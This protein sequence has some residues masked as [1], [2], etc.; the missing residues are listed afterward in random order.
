MIRRTL[1]FERP[2]NLPP[3]Q[4][5]PLDEEILRHV[6]RHRFL[7]AD[8]VVGLVGEPKGSVIRRLV[9]LFEHGF[10]DRPRAQFR[11][12][13]SV[14]V[15]YRG[16]ELR[17]GIVPDRVFRLSTRDE[18]LLFCLEVDRGTMS[19]VRL[20]P[21][22]SSFYRK[23]LALPRDVAQRTARAG[24]GMAALPGAHAA[25]LDGAAR[26]LGRCAKGGGRGRRI[27]AVPLRGHGHLQEGA[28][29]DGDAVDHRGRAERGEDPC[30]DEGMAVP[31][32][33]AGARIRPSCPQAESGPW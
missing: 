7:R 31:R 9:L 29:P 16:E 18:T 30:G 3:F 23:L 4:F 26:P 13:A 28:D 12:G 24:A 33:R 14:P 27:R 11:Y 20:N 17:A 25:V 19:V 8:Q 21:A 1:L 5:A 10:L 15:H 6:L 32:R 22:Q 2:S